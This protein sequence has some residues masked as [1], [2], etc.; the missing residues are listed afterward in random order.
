MT[1]AIDRPIGDESERI[2]MYPTPHDDFER[3]LGP[4]HRRYFG[5]GYRK[6]EY[7]VPVLARTDDDT[8]TG[9]AA[10][11]YASDWSSKASSE[12]KPH[13]ST[14]DATVL[15]GHAAERALQSL[16]GLSPAEVRR[17]WIER[18]DVR[19]GAK[20]LESTSEVP[21][22]ITRTD[23]GEVQDD[24]V[25]TPLQTTLQCRIGTF[26][27]ALVVRHPVPESP[28]T[29]R[30]TSFTDGRPS[31]AYRGTTHTSTITRL[32]I[33]DQLVACTH[34]AVAD[35]MLRD[36]AAL[37]S[38]HDPIVGMIDRLVLAGQ[39]AQVLIYA[40]DGVD[41]DTT[42]NLWMRRAT[43]IA[44]PPAQFAAASVDSTLRV[45]QRRSFARD[46]GSVRTVDVVID[47]LFGVHIESSLAYLD[48]GPA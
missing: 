27:V 33:E 35:P 20:P 37:E 16:I 47:D 2:P 28:D 9:V 4:S 15:A 6:T 21:L 26:Q 48:A 1:M 39:M 41:R 25:G 24:A 40:T 8:L 43:I 42:A 13:A 44:E 19:A 14:V 34:H 31:T 46:G 17:A 22:S 38:A 18:I 3:R 23:T 32:S 36:D 7:R 11:D 45:S 10:I 5:A 30:P 12:R 29:S